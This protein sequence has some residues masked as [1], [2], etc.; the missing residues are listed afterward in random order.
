LGR[1]QTK[2]KNIAISLAIAF[3]MFPLITPPSASATTS[4]QWNLSITSLNGTTIN[5]S[6]DVIL[7]MPKM[8]VSADLSCYGNLIS[9]GAWGG[10]VLSD[11]LNLSGIDSSVA[12]IDFTAQDGYSVNIP[13]KTAMRSDIIVAYDLDGSQLNEVLRLVVPEENGNIWIAKITSIKMSISSGDQVQ[14]ETSGQSIINQ[15]HAIVNTTTPAPQQLKPQVD[16][17]PIVPSNETTIKPVTPPT[18]ITVPQSEQKIV[19][20]EDSGSPFKFVLVFLVAVVLVIVTGFIVYSRKKTQL[21]NI[22][23]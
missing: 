3:L 22:K 9:S 23:Y 1:T 12:V 4:T 11:L 8:I 13:I 19:R 20:E 14:S 10:V 16:T 21:P 6:Y 2:Y 5:L 17:Q 18:V 7:A 15:Y